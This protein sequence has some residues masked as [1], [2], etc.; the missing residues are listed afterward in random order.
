M[1]VGGQS[2]IA[3]QI[4]IQCDEREKRKTGQLLKK[5][6]ERLLGIIALLHK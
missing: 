6:N 5:S 4:A 1:K 3:I 2:E